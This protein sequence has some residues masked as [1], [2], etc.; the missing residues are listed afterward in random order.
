MSKSVSQVVKDI[1]AAYVSL[2]KTIPGNVR[3]NIIRMDGGNWQAYL[4]GI[5][6][7][8]Y[9]LRGDTLEEAVLALRHALSA[10]A[11]DRVAR[12]K[13]ELAACEEAI[14]LLDEE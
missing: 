4:A 12:T 6:E 14:G 10:V 11:H 3:F 5:R 7:G 9:N 13:S 1:V 8:D 2:Y